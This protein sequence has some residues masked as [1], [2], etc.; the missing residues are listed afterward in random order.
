MSADLAEASSLSAAAARELTDQIRVAVDA[1]WHLVVRAYRE[2]ADLALGYSSWDDYCRAEFWSSRIRLPREERSEVVASLREQGMS[3]R[4]ISAATGA[5]TKTVTKD[6][7]QVWESPTPAP[8][9]A[10]GESSPPVENATP[11]ATPANPEPASD[12]ALAP[13]IG[14]D[15]KRYRPRQRAERPATPRRAPLP[16]AAQ[17]AGFEFRRVVERLERIGADD[18]F[19]AN[20]E[21]VAA[22]LRGHLSYAIE[23]CQ[24]LLD[25]LNH[26]SKED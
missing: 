10:G 18:R 21:Q 25:R 7:L 16:D 20:K 23:V 15:G 17:R 19:A 2:R 12:H 9:N 11:A 14:L 24:D 22:H 4:A 3:L 26:Q 5:A 6:L 8:A 13:V 1:T